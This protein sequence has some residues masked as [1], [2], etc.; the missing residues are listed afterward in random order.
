V[1]AALEALIAKQERGADA[2]TTDPEAPEGSYERHLHQAHEALKAYL[3]RGGSGSRRVEFKRM[4]DLVSA[5]PTNLP[6]LIEGVAPEGSVIAASAEPKSV[7]SWAVDHML[8][9]I[10]NAVPAFGEF[11]VPCAGQ[12][13]LFAAEDSERSLRTRFLA[14]ARGLG[15]DPI[16]A[17]DRVA[18]QSRG[19][20]DLRKDADVCE[21]IAAARM[22]APNG[23]RALALDPLRDVHGA[24]EDKGDE[25]EPVMANLRALRDILGCSVFFV[26]HT[27]KMSADKA[28]RRRGQMMR[29]STVIHASIDAGAY[30]VLEEHTPTSWRNSV[31]FET[32]EGRSAGLVGL[33]LEIEDNDKGEAQVARWSCSREEE[34]ADLVARL[35]EVLRAAP[36]GENG[37]TIRE[38]QGALEVRTQL[39]SAAVALA[40]VS[41]QVRKGKTRG[42]VFA[43]VA[44]S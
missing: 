36:A 13:L 20:I 29:G 26:H 25:M 5:P 3:G 17:L 7:K 2:F 44:A 35:V 40:V 12:V 30:M 31:L 38:L 43:G 37:M 22:A 39:V 11:I 32:R 16:A 19:R 42:Y 41:G 33:K 6:W 23:L 24:Q 9:C 14:T 1:S 34:S 18:Y 4:A 27:A 8:V 15:L 28:N 21:V 10:A